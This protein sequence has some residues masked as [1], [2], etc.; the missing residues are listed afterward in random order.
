MPYIGCIPILEEIYIKQ[1]HGHMGY[2]L[3]SL[4]KDT[5]SMSLN[6]GMYSCYGE[7]YTIETSVN[8]IGIIIVVG[9]FNCKGILIMFKIA[10]KIAFFVHTL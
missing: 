6:L 3:A 4:N 7:I 10:F 1:Y 9:L 5:F 2:R 8:F